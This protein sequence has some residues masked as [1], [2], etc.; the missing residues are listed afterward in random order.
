MWL[1]CIACLSAYLCRHQAFV[2]WHYVV[3][4]NFVSD[5]IDTSVVGLHSMCVFLSLAV[6]VKTIWAASLLTAPFLPQLR[7]R[8]PLAA[9]KYA[10]P[11]SGILL[12]NSN[13]RG[14]Q[15]WKCVVRQWSCIFCTSAGLCLAVSRSVGT[16]IS[17]H[18][19]IENAFSFQQYSKKSEN[20]VFE[21][22]LAREK[23]EQHVVYHIYHVNVGNC[24]K[25]SFWSFESALILPTR[26]TTSTKHG[27]P[28]IGDP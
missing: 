22:I 12:G 21:L 10:Q 11:F 4:T 5:T 6:F 13:I 8:G 14:L 1:I 27:P 3:R 25:R 24:I 7:H 28:E 19:G 16:N 17:I 2:K 15:F 20:R 23:C 18:F 9:A 26:L